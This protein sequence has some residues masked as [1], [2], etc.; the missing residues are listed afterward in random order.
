MAGHKSA[1]RIYYTLILAKRQRRRDNHFFFFFFCVWK[2]R[3][4]KLI[5]T[6]K[7]HTVFGFACGLTQRMTR[8]IVCHGVFL[9]GKEERGITSPPF[10]RRYSK[11]S[12]LT[13]GPLSRHSPRPTQAPA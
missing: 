9:R 10:G 6:P 2:I 12:N 8:R 11:E 5:I 4:K 7:P 3:V 1:T 13:H